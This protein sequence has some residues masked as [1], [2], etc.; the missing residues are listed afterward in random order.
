VYFSEVVSSVQVFIVKLCV[1]VSSLPRVLYVLFEL[2][3]CINVILLAVMKHNFLLRVHII[4]IQTN[5]FIFLEFF[6]SVAHSDGSESYKD[7]GHDLYLR[8]ALSNLRWLTVLPIVT[9]FP[10]YFKFV[11]I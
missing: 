4:C 3:I 10:K 11:T 6:Y 5:V 7:N 8:C 9:P 1:Q 2:Y